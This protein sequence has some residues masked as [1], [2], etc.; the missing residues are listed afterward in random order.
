MGRREYGCI[1]L[2]SVYSEKLNLKPNQV[3]MRVFFC[4]VFCSLFFFFF[5]CLFCFCFCFEHGLIMLSRLVLNSR[6]KWSTCLSVPI[7]WRCR[8]LVLCCGDVSTPHCVYVACVCVCVCVC[9]CA[10][11]RI[12][13][14]VLVCVCM[15]LRGGAGEMAQWLRALTAF[16]K[17]LSSNPS[18]HMVPYNHQ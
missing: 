16:L 15:R 11:T 3:K 2:N 4:F 5:V 12:H 1:I 6:A 17:F 18:N 8:C 7:S 14:S 9:V 13:V 10:R